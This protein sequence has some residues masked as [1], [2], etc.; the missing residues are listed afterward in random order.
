MS[1][2]T[3]P[4]NQAKLAGAARHLGEHGLVA[5]AWVGIGLAAVFLV[6][7]CYARWRESARLFMDDYWMVASFVFLLANGILQTLQAH[8]LYYLVD[9]AAGRV[10]EGP[11]LLVQGNQ[12]VRYEFTIIAFFWT[13]TWCVKGSFL[14]LY[15]RLFDGLPHYRKLWYACVVFTIGAYIGCWMASVWTCHPPSTYFQFGMGDEISA[16]DFQVLILIDR[17]MQQACR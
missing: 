7:R 8:S 6:L 9:L 13:I 4:V 11:E 1:N 12:Y 2:N 3:E 15:Y 5:I 17:S 16:H 10:P 14:A